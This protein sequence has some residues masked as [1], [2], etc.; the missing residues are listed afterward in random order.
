MGTAVKTAAARGGRNVDQL[1]TDYISALGD[2]L[3]Y[4]LR[5]KLGDGVVKSTPLEFVV[6]VPA[7]WSDL[8][9]DKTRQACQRAAGLSATKAPIHL[10]SEPEAAA[11]YALHGLDPHGLQVGDSFVICDAGGGTVDLISYT[12]TKLKPILEVQEAT[13]GSGALCGSTFLNMR[14]A[15]FLKAK[16]GKEEGFDDEVLADAMERFE[17][18]VGTPTLSQLFGH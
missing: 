13:P 4:T 8:A 7:I 16:L 17:K 3:M 9:K 10:V 14:F 15:K 6:T 1:V 18:T 11:I 12:I 2:H 5:E